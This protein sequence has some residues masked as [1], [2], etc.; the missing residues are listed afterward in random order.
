M[1]NVKIL[2]PFERGRRQLR[3]QG[4]QRDGGQG[5]HASPQFR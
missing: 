2:E 3:C 4:G 1:T 5:L